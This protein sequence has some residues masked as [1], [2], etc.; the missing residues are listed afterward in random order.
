M[1]IARCGRGD[2]GQRRTL[3]SDLHW[4]GASLFS[5]LSSQLFSSRGAVLF[6]SFLCACGS[7][8]AKP[9]LVEAGADTPSATS[10]VATESPSAAPIGAPSTAPSIPT[11]MTG[12]SGAS[13]VDL[14]ECQPS[15]DA[16]EGEVEG[17][18]QVQA[19]PLTLSGP[20]DLSQFALGCVQ[21][22]TLSSSIEIS[23]SL[24]IDAGGHLID[25]TTTVGTHE[26][27]VPAKCFELTI[28]GSCND[29]PQPL[30]TLGYES[31]AC[32]EQASG[33]C[34]CIGTFNQAGGLALLSKEPMQSADVV[35]DGTTLVA[36]DDE[37]MVTYLYCAAG[38]VLTL[39]VAQLSAVGQVE[40]S[41]VLYRND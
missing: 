39:R 2:S 33:D 27:L 22:K 30:K 36:N 28:T 23:G 21:G 17:T 3:G 35:T 32:D 7:Y 38:D 25:N 18:W 4:S 34:V 41:V 13:S 16:C 6:S 26:F 8:D 20:I 37:Q 10:S 1:E 14:P 9:A 12:S 31:V 29:L 11:Q 15:V 40:G 5:A 19:C 24:Q